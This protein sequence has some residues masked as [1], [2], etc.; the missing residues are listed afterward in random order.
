MSVNLLAP[1]IRRAVFFYTLTLCSMAK[2]SS[3]ICTLNLLLADKHLKMAPP[4]AVEPAKKALKS[5]QGFHKQ[6]EA[7]IRSQGAELLTWSNEELGL[8]VKAGTD[9]MALLSKMIETARKHAG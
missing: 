3:M 9:A 2:T 4:F 8:E 6:S 5:L 7:C 1:K